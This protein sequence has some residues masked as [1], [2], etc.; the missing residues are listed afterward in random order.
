MSDPKL[1]IYDLCRV[2]GNLGVDP[3]VNKAHADL[4]DEELLTV[5]VKLVAPVYIP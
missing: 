5:E 3:P 1:G 2:S 4:K